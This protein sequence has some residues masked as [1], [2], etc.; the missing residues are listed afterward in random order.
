LSKEKDKKTNNIDKIQYKECKISRKFVLKS[1]M[2]VH[3]DQEIANEIC[4]LKEITSIYE[5]NLGVKT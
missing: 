3:F 1:Y 4:Q 5:L 2:K